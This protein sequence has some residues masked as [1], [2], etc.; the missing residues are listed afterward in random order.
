MEERGGKD[1]GPGARLG[2]TAA[3]SLPL[4]RA[5]LLLV[6]PPA[7]FDFRG[8]RDVYFPFM[9]TSGDIPITPLY[10]VFPLGF[11]AMERYLGSRGFTVKIL[12]LATLLLLHRE[13][14]LRDVLAALEVKV[15]G[16]DL[17]WLVH[18][19]GALAVAACVKRQRPDLPVLFGGI[20]ATYYAEELIRLPSVDLVLRGYDT[21][22]PM[23]ELMRAGG[24]S[25]DDLS[26]VPNLL[27]KERDGAIRDNGLLH[28][29][30]ALAGG[31]DW[32]TAP[33]DP[34]GLNAVRELLSNQNA[35]CAY[36]CGWCGGGRSAFKRLYGTDRSLV[37][38][39]DPELECELDSFSLRPQIETH[40][41]YVEG[42][43]NES[44]R[45]LELIFDSVERAGLNSVNYSLF[46]LPSDER[47]RRMV[48]ASKRSIITLSPQSHDLRVAKLAG[49]GVFTN[50]EL[51]RWIDRALELGIAKVDLWYFIGMPE[52]DET[53]VLGTIDHCK[54]ILS[55]FPKGTVYPMIC[56]MMPF[57]DVGSAFFEQPERHGY[58][59][60]YRTLEEHRAGAERPSLIDRL[61][62]ETRWM[63][64]AEIVSLG[65]RA[66]RELMAAKADVGLF[67][68]SRVE[69]FNR[70]LDDAL[71]LTLEVRDAD[72][73]PDPAARSRRLEGLGNEV[74]R[75][76]EETLYGGVIDQVYPVKHAIGS[77]W[78]DE[79]GW[80]P[81][82]PVKIGE[83]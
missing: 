25:G 78:F 38:K 55:R 80:D 60:F 72:A 50:E 70:R 65:Y 57:L 69:A 12:N 53:S 22:E 66:I 14:D 9:G 34:G 7:F 83:S 11:K 24:R 28:L 54:K 79:L 20:S 5:D 46:Q 4:L 36:D 42:A 40:H 31:I 75:R 1:R 73:I 23:T 59:T 43:Y 29:P 68:P 15:L 64:R 21:L 76:N 30:P 35:G 56:P 81:E 26:R 17:H 3:G 67:P 19:Q 44:P 61:N 47:I 8:R 13:L 6:H 37:R 49:R 16:I 27:W 48:R 2:A 45:R 62:Y 32:G 18:A 52:Q 82:L 58:R 41:L 71:A 33:P 10:E 51:E 74:L 63:S 39:A 77:R